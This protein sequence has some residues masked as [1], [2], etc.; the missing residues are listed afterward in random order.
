MTDFSLRAQ[1]VAR[2]TYL[3]PVP[4]PDGTEVFETW[5]EMIDRVID[6]QR[7]LYERALGRRLRRSHRAELE[8]LRALL[9]D[10]RGALAG[11]TYWLGGTN[12]SRECECSQFN[13][14]FLNVEN[15]YNVVDAAWLL[16]NGCGVGFRG[17]TG[18]LFSFPTP[19]PHIEIV[20]GSPDPDFRGDPRNHEDSTGGV[21]TIR[22]GDSA[23]AWA[24]AIGKL[25]SGCH[26]GI[27]TLRLDFS[28][29]RGPGGRLRA[30]GWICH[31]YEPL[32]RAMRAI[33][34]IRNRNPGPNAL[35]RAD[36]HDILNHI[37]T[38]LSTRRSAQLALCDS[39]DPDLDEFVHFKDNLRD[40][41]HRAQ[42]N[43]TINFTSKPSLARL[44]E[45][46]HDMIE[47][48]R[49]E[50]GIRNAAECTRRAPWSSG[51]N[52]CAEILLPSNGFCN[53][54]EINAAHP[55][56]TDHT[57]L[58]RTAE[59]LARA[60]YRQTCVHLD[61]D[62]ILQSAWHEN[63]QHLRLCGVGITGL[64]QAPHVRLPEVRIAAHIGAYGMADDLGLPRPAL[65]TTV[66]PSGTMSKVMD[67][68][69]G[70]HYPIARFVRNNIRFSANDPLLDTFREW[71]LPIHE[72][73]AD[74]AGCVVPF[75]V[76]YGPHVVPAVPLT[77]DH[78]LR[79]Y[80]RINREYA[81]HNTSCTL[82]YDPDVD[83]ADSMAAAIL[84]E[85]DNGL[86]AISML[87]RTGANYPLMPQEPMTME[88]Y[89]REAPR[90]RGLRLP[91]F[92]GSASPYVHE[93]P[94][95]DCP[96]GACPV[97]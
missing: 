8:A 21:W 17:R 64:A 32:A 53:L 42:S 73:P 16:L 13:C 70:M 18:S 9:L 1:V 11:R 45:I 52:P 90:Y 81:D 68:T 10:R 75:P 31:G 36:I 46:L 55:A 26:P 94:T 91:E 56:H 62:P 7:F 50:P 33:A 78:Q 23:E 51:S 29:V 69:E 82:M 24:K 25:L 40:Q 84:R 48:R 63:N 12:K 61:T 88:E 39:T 20:P 14:A 92:S 30:Y 4:G 97:R 77:F 83:T 54:V 85:W 71:G 47:S 19:V 35:R 79:E 41:P 6:H 34:D 2:R 59:L 37:G 95:E 44:T 74:P 22:V 65:V 96:G 87:P 76:D 43:N 67:C 66:K 80:V 93:D 86:C 60:N 89:A 5:P 72:D 38:V 58:E 15:V 28:R 49:G 3:R 27:H 57:E